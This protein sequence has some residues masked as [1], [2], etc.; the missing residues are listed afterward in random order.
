DARREGADLRPQRRA[1]LRRGRRRQ[2]QRDPEGLPH[3]HEDGVPRRGP[4]SEPSLVRLGDRMKF[5]LRY[6]SLGK[7]SNGVAAGEL[8]QA[9]EEA[10]FD[11]I[12]TVEHVIV[13]RDYQS[14]YPY[15]PSGRMGSGLE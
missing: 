10:G 13:P 4:L 6:A 15:S 14:K 2:A 11:S 5:G 3:T 9:A 12:W 7:Y 1:P 8:A